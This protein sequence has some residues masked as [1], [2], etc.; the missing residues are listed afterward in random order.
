MLLISSSECGAL[1]VEHLG[2]ENMRVEVEAPFGNV[3]YCGPTPETAKARAEGKD[4]QAPAFLPVRVSA[5]EILRPPRNSGGLLG[6]WGRWGGGE[7]WSL[8]CLKGEGL[9]SG[10]AGA[11]G[12]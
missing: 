9:S 6:S 12:P 2:L 8:A 10:Y 7:F 4:S 5:S 11:T 3:R 1:K